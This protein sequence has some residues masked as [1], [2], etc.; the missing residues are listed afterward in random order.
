MVALRI[1]RLTGL[2]VSS[3]SVTDRFSSP[4]RIVRP[5]YGCAWPAR[6]RRDGIC[7]RLEKA[8]IAAERDALPRAP[9]NRTGSSCKGSTPI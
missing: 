1:P 3:R 9:V 2:R 6:C 8:D 7:W 5:C 4:N